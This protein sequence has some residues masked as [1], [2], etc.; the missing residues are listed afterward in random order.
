MM[1]GFALVVGHI[2]PGWLEQLRGTEKSLLMESEKAQRKTQIT[3]AA[4]NGIFNV[5]ALCG[6]FSYQDNHL[7]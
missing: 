2:S 3:T 1:L 7:K 6:A 4:P 5:F